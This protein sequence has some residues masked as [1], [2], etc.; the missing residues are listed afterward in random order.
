MK[1]TVQT[2]H[3]LDIVMDI[4]VPMDPI[5]ILGRFNVIEEQDKREVYIDDKRVGKKVEQVILKLLD[6]NTELLM[7]LGDCCD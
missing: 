4:R 7:D 1:K 6:D 2:R 3:G 5:S